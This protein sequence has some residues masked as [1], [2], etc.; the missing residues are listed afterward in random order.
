MRIAEGALSSLPN[1]SCIHQNEWADCAFCAFSRRFARFFRL[2]KEG[3]RKDWPR[4]GF[5]L[6][7]CAQDS[8]H[9]PRTP[10]GTHKTSFTIY[11]LYREG[12][13]RLA[14]GKQGKRGED[15]GLYEKFHGCLQGGQGW[16]TPLHNPEWCCGIL[17]DSF[18]HTAKPYELLGP[19]GQRPVCAERKTFRRLV[20]PC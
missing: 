18:Q 14:Q 13:P 20:R 9:A 1:N 16:G 11:L 2:R 5:R 15:A 19:G 6:L 12:A 7:D 8:Q 10:C 3:I 4:K 17:P